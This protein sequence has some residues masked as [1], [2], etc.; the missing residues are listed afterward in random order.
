MDLDVPGAT[1]SNGAVQP[2]F[3]PPFATLP[4]L[5]MP[6][7]VPMAPIPIAPPIA[8]VILQTEAQPAAKRPK[9]V[10]TSSSPSVH[11]TMHIP[12]IAT[13]IPTSST[14]IEA[15][16]K[17]SAPKKKTASRSKKLT[18]PT[19]GSTTI[20]PKKAES[21][22]PNDTTPLRASNKAALEAMG[23]SWKEPRY[24]PHPALH[25]MKI[26]LAPH[27]SSKRV[28][29][30]LDMAANAR[31]YNLTRANY[32]VQKGKWYY[33]LLVTD[34][35]TILIQIRDYQ[36]KQ[37]EDAEN[38]HGAAKRPAEPPT[39]N[40]S[41]HL[42]PVATP[43]PT[44]I[45]STENQSI[46][47]HNQ[48]SVGET[49]PSRA[50]TPSFA[51]SNSELFVPPSTSSYTAPNVEP[52]PSPSIPL[53]RFPNYDASQYASNA[54]DLSDMDHLNDATRRPLPPP[55]WRL[56]WATEQADSESPVGT[57]N[58][59]ISWRDDGTLFHLAR[60]LPILIERN[61]KSIAADPTSRIVSS[62]SL[63]LN[64]GAVGQDEEDFR[65]DDFTI[66]D[67]L[68][69]AIELP[70]SNFDFIKKLHQHQES[71]LGH[72]DTLL[73]LRRTVHINTVSLNYPGVD[74]AALTSQIQEAQA[75]IAAIQPVPP[76]EHP[77][78]LPGARLSFYKNG[79]LQ[80][81]SIIN[82]P[83]GSYYPAVSMYYQGAIMVNFGPNFSHPPPPEFRPASELPDAYEIPLPGA[84]FIR[85]VPTTAS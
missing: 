39:E 76:F 85:P 62:P 7:R 18:D 79:V 15:K 55:H 54:T 41:P 59:G 37:E 57:D 34:A 80:R 12:P 38:V 8:P 74:V 19:A 16:L 13:Q 5:P 84:Q 21:G 48:D 52:T 26:A 46:Q 10:E 83:P 56:G 31:G 69:F 61:K 75:Q 9:L 53:V 51:P 82:S 47:P 22:T 33:E 44:T 23:L 2:T 67:V 20:A 30:H 49:S 77:A 3:P 60:P 27:N 36:S 40:S 43:A 24:Q 45:S 29:I 72:Q 11:A 25:P 32:P 1:S 17:D 14:S 70:D 73:K 6:E 78:T 64:D 4:F 58:F 71:V 68:G 28:Q 66:G 63:E 65:I 42:S 35:P 81:V 50:D